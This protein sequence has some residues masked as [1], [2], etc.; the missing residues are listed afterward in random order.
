[1]WNVCSAWW[2]PVASRVNDKGLALSVSC[3]LSL[4]LSLS[5]SLSLSFSFLS[6]SLYLSFLFLFKSPPPS[7]PPSLTHSL[8]HSLP[9]PLSI[10]IC[11]SQE[12]TVD[13]PSYAPTN[14]PLRE[15][16]RVRAMTRTCERAKNFTHHHPRR[17]SASPPSRIL[18]KY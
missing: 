14:P 13:R 15:R 10:C 8:L 11:C 7:L 2:T 1:V 9:P 6:L 4:F 5:L 17:L 3:R 18:A 16:T 12:M